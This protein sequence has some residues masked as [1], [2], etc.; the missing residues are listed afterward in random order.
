LLII[1]A[2]SFKQNGVT[3]LEAKSHYTIVGLV[4]LILTSALLSTFL[5]LSTGFDKKKYNYYMVYIDEAVSGLNLE[6]PVKFNGVKVG[7]VNQIELNPKDPQQVKLLLKIEQGVPITESTS[8]TLISQGITGISTVGLSASSSELTPLRAKANQP[9]PVIPSKPSLFNQLDNVLRGV[10]DNIS[11]VS[12]Q[13]KIVFNQK[14]GRH[15]TEILN[16]IEHITSTLDNNKVKLNRAIKNADIVLANMAIASRHFPNMA[17]ALKRGSKQLGEAG[18]SVTYTMKA[19]RVTLNELS[20]QTLPPAMALL[21]K[22]NTMA[23]YL[24]QMSLELKNNPSVILRGTTQ[25]PLG[26]GEHA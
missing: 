17:I 20:T 16:H 10:S 4:V 1:L 22:L 11:D 8:A 14:N 18:Q 6:S 9:Y 7:Y 21:R 13:M 23:D 26:P 5:W 2:N 3:T 15:F 24:E 19:A 12:H 25:S